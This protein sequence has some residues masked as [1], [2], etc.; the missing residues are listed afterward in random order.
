MLR[1]L[2]LAGRCPRAFDPAVGDAA[3]AHV[4]WAEGDIAALIRGAAGT[5]PYLAQLVA[6]EGDWLE[7][8]AQDPAQAAADLV[9]AVRSLDPGQDPSVPL[10]QAKRRMA[11]LAALCDLAGFWPLEQVTGALTGLADAAC[12]AALTAA[13]ARARC[14]P[15]MP[16]VFAMGKMG[17]AELNYSSD[18]DLIC[19]FDDAGM[20]P[21]DIAEARA[22]LSRVIRRMSGWLNDVTADGYVFRT[23][24]RLRPDPSVTPVCIAMGAAEQYYETLGRTWERAA[25]VKA[26]PCAGDLAAG[27]RFIDA[28]RPF[29]WRRHLDFAAIEDAHNMR[30]A[31]RE[32]KGLHGPI[33]LPRHDL[34]LGRGGIRE[35]EFFTQTRQIIA[36]GRDDTLRLRATVPALARLA[37]QGWVPADTAEALTSSYRTLR[38][39]EHRVQMLRDA[40]THALP[41]NDDEW[42]RLSA[43]MDTTAD[44]L[45]SGLRDVLEDVHDRT[46]RFF[47]PGQGRTEDV[48]GPLAD[49]GWLRYPAL[50]SDRAARIFRRLQPAILA[51][52]AE[53]PRPDEARAAFD[54]F[55]AG[56]PAGVQLF[57][58]FEANPQLVDLLVEV[59]SVGPELA[60]YLARHP[61]V[62]DA[63]IAGD[64][65]APWPG[66]ARLNLEAE[67]CLAAEDDYEAQLDA[68][69]RWT[70]DWQFRIGVHLLRGVTPPDE[71]AGQYAG[72]ARAGLTALWPAVVAEF[73]LKHGPP[74]GRG[75][76]VLGMGSLG[77]GR[78]HARSDLDL[79]VIYDPGS[80]ETSEGRR[81]LAVRPYY[82]RLTQALV[83]ALTAPTAEGRLYEVDMR[84]R[85][86]GNKGPVATSWRAFQDYQATEAWTWEHMALIRAAPVAGTAA[87][88]GDLD[89]FLDRLLTPPRPEGQVLND[90]AT[91][92][93]RIAEASGPAP[94]W[95]VK[96]GQGRLQDIELFAQ[97][98]A[99]V[100]GA[101]RGDVTE[102]LEAALSLGWITKVQQDALASAHALCWR[103]RMAEQLIGRGALNPDTLGQ[104]AR[105]FVARV[106]R[107][108]APGALDRRLHDITSQAAEI[109]GAVLEER[110]DHEPQ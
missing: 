41:G 13:M 71:A 93:R 30:L 62:F 108:D 23:D 84:L 83:T 26:R 110:A 96:L 35:I 28:L 65:F 67:R 44:A 9:A 106:T 29:I 32:A 2:A 31:I 100:R 36:G 90:L 12:A 82:A 24:L 99:L 70:R 7:G 104:G 34:K 6:R 109:I 14:A 20:D 46:D 38:E 80:A 37:E 92:R 15:P 11:L 88:C 87:L 47:D 56:L 73:S 86:S 107:E 50:R 76:A 5:A 66:Q 33:T 58:L 3:L 77:S 16:T 17:A 89:R 53:A 95:E 55:L 103:L 59:V 74:P 63:V 42:A 97:S 1:P 91:M 4:P 45:R 18:I 43:L 22:Q 54:R 81:P 25:W 19:L 52:L 49:E 79:I 64:F 48:P 10:R 51:R 68:A 75:A 27:A 69:R 8:A 60:A 61:Q 85:P 72:L 102:G 105:A 57:S 94:A 101:T 78:L 39:A 40:Q 21:S 98:A